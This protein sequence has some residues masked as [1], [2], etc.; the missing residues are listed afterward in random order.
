[1]TFQPP[2]GPGQFCS[3]EPSRAVRAPDTEEIAASLRKRIVER[4]QRN[5][6]DQI[7]DLDASLQII[8]NARNSERNERERINIRE[9]GDGVDP[10]RRVAYI[11]R[12]FFDSQMLFVTLRSPQ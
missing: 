7:A 3:D 6:R 5:L 10:L 2:A 12:Q 1:M 9:L 4:G 8:V 11:S